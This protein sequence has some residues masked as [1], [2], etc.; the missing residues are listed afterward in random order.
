[1]S[2]KWT[3]DNALPIIRAIDQIAR[4]CNF[5]LALR[6]GVLLDGESQRDLDLCLLSEDDREFCSAEMVLEEIARGM[7]EQVERYNDPSGGDK[8][9]HTIIRLRDGRRIDAHFWI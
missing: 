4:R 2:T 6:G 3:R 7:P 5:S 1:M 9:L 8:Y